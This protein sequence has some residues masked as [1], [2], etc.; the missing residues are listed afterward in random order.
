MMAVQLKLK[1]PDV[2]CVYQRSFAFGEKEQAVVWEGFLKR[3][4][5]EV[6]T[7]LEEDGWRV[8]YRGKRR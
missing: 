1:L 7:V 6:R 4:F 8:L 3:K 5:V 2:E